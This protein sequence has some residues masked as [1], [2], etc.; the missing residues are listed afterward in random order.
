MGK[1]FSYGGDAAG[2]PRKRA[3]VVHE[4]PTS[5]EVHASRQLRQLLV[6]DQDPARSRHGL[7]LPFPVLAGQ[8]C[9]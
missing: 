8:L 5:E 1:R 4:A 6:F 3:K 2:G 9:G 7:Y